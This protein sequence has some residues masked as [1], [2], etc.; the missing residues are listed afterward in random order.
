MFILS[1]YYS[2]YDQ[3]HVYYLAPTKEEYESWDSPKHKQ[4]D[5][6]ITDDMLDGE[7][8]VGIPA[9]TQVIA[10]AVVVACGTHMR[11]WGSKF[12]RK[13]RSRFTGQILDLYNLAREHIP[14]DWQG[15][16]GSGGSTI[17]NGRVLNVQGMQLWVGERFRLGSHVY[18]R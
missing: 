15:I 8:H 6:Y 5:K 4:W 13:S 1:N 9:E 17:E 7:M 14:D 12:F 18:R 2:D 10:I 3:K 11:S 16:P